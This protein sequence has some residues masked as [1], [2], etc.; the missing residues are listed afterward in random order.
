M[1]FQ[2]PSIS[3]LRSGVIHVRTSAL[4]TEGNSTQAVKFCDYLESRADTEEWLCPLVGKIGMAH[5]THRIAMPS[6]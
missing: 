4:F 3:S 1:A 6:S 5:V 2:G